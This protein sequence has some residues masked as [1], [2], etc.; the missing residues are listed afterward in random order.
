MSDTSTVTNTKTFIKPPSQW[1]VIFHNDD[2]TPMEFVQQ[3]LIQIFRK[4]KQDA[5]NLAYEVHTKEKA[6]VGIYTKEIANTRVDLT[7]YYAQ[8]HGYPLKASAEEA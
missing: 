8:S 4:S 3:L 7:H 1:K 6:I 5:F 2:T